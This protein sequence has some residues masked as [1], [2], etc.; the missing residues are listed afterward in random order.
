[1]L[2]T[3][4]K[5]MRPKQWVKNV[6]IFAGVV[7][8]R[9]LS[10]PTALLA[11][12]EAAALFSLLASAV[13]LVNDISDLESDREHLTKKNRPIASGA[14]P[15]SLAWGVALVL[16]AVVFYFGYQLSSAFALICAVYAALNLMYS[17]WFK[18]MV[19]LDVLILAGF[20][21]IRVVVGLTVISVDRF[22]PWLYLATI[23][24]ALFMGVGK[25]RAEL[26]SA[27]QSG[28][29]SRKV[30]ELYTLDYLDQ[31]IMIVLTSTIMTYS[32]YTFSA[33]NLPDNYATMLTIPF[34][35]YGVFRYLYLLQVQQHGEAPEDIVLSDRPFQINL[36]L[37]A[38]S[39]LLIFY[40]F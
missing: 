32:L 33:P 19:I 18:H 40:Y 29:N 31:I 39:I 3:I 10:D 36:V 27:Q 23:F 30:L 25:R 1:M 8:D 24:L 4:L 2:R 12:I 17:R 22:S 9:K 26:I 15:I 16:F 5:A 7:F 35:I 28:S 13:Y 21:V 38:I 14:L 20:Y 34:V 11:T 37:W 6:L